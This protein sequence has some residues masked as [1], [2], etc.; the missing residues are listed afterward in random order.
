MM[1]RRMLLVKLGV[2]T[3]LIWGFFFAAYYVML[4][5]VIF[6]SCAATLCFII[7]TMAGLAIRPLMQ[8]FKNARA[9]R[10]AE[11]EDEV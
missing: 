3:A 10:I 2:L 7:F 1:S 8:A 6:A 9:E 5:D 4:A 11:E